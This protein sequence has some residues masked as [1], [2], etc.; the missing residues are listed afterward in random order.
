[1]GQPSGL[2]A[3][4]LPVCAP[5]DDGHGARRP[6]HAAAM[7]CGTAAVLAIADADGGAHIGA[8]GDSSGHTRGGAASDARRARLRPRP[9]ERA[10]GCMPMAGA[11]C[12]HGPSAGNGG[13]CRPNWVGASGDSPA[14][15]RA[16]SVMDV[17]VLPF[18]GLF[19]LLQPLASSLQLG[20]LALQL[21]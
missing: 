20:V 19:E 15:Q 1:M 12:R 7:H 10:P 4:R 5:T 16:C 2:T 14:A 3:A 21:R 18:E 6:R 8:A 9:R 11:S 17:S 13:D